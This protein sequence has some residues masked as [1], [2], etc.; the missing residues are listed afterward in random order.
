MIMTKKTAAVGETM[1]K[2]DRETV[3]EFLCELLLFSCFRSVYSVLKSTDVVFLAN[4]K[5]TK[6]RSKV[7]RIERRRDLE[8]RSSGSGSR[9]R[10]WKWF[11]S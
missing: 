4:A 3:K 1:A 9:R 6:E 8:K 7:G 2:T 5:S 11:C 10:R